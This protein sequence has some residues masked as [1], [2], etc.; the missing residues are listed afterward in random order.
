MKQAVESESLRT[1]DLVLY[2]LVVTLITWKVLEYIGIISPNF[3]EASINEIK[4]RMT[5]DIRVELPDIVAQQIGQQIHELVLDKIKLEGQISSAIDSNTDPI[6]FKIGKT[7]IRKSEFQKKFSQFV[8]RPEFKNL[9]HTDQKQKF[10]EQ[11]HKHYAILEDSRD[12]GLESRPEFVQ[13][14]EEFRFKVFISE[15]LRQQI[16]P[17]GMNDVKAYYESNKS[18]FEKDEV[19]DFEVIESSDSESLQAVNTV[20]KFDTTTLRKEYLGQSETATP[21][22]FVKALRSV[23]VGQLTAILPLQGKYYLLKKTAESRK[24][25]SPIDQVAPFIQNTLTFER[26]RLLLSKLSN[27]LKF[28]FDVYLEKDQ[29]YK[30]K[31]EPVDPK[32]LNFARSILPKEFFIKA[33]QS[34]TEVRDLE[35][36][37]EILYR[38]FNLNPM[39]YSK[40]LQDEVEAKSDAYREQLVVEFKRK[41]ILDQAKVSEVELKQYYQMHKDKFVQSMGR[42][43]SHIFISDK[44]KAL[45]VLN[46]ALDD[47]NGFAQLAKEHSE[48]PL[49][50]QYGGD[51][52]YMD[53]SEVSNAMHRVAETLKEGEIH[54]E[55]VPGING[56][57]NHILQYV[58]NVPG[59]V[60]SFEEIRDRLRSSIIQE[61][62]NQLLLAFISEVIGK[63]PAK[64]DNTLLAQL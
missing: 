10:T 23:D 61:R 25:H 50:R 16:D 14:I 43:V 38:K 35:V 20:K 41:E 59:K 3:S 12:S 2:L 13:K 24:I 46:M 8:I 58:K 29:V 49:T 34:Q 39:Q 64:I 48:H 37:F 56:E 11:L 60:A 42:W 40:S 53:K 15:L 4:T 22:Q 45:K 32:F 17:I 27:P 7:I 51:M 52:R 1:K 6:I 18:L 21:I 44:S 63:Y 62:Q 33:E 47:P 31:G 57:G 5:E 55:L 26:I 19:F 36:E 30:I 9:S 54:P 28:E